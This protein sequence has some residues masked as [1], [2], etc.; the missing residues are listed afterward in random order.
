MTKT[1]LKQLIKQVLNEGDISHWDLE[2]KHSELFKKYQHL[3]APGGHFEN[4]LKDEFTIES[5]G[6]VLKQAII[7]G[8][9]EGR[10][11]RKY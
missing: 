11:N 1:E 4:F 9:T 5:F 2:D 8:Y 10:K 7:F 3:Y 6:E